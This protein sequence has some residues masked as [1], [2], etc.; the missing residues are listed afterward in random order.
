[1]GIFSNIISNVSGFINTIKDKPVTTGIAISQITNP[2][3]GVPTIANILTQKPSTTV[4]TMQTVNSATGIVAGGATTYATK[5]L[6]LGAG[7]SSIFGGVSALSM[8]ETS[9]KTSTLTKAAENLGVSKI[10]DVTKFVSD[11]P[12]GTATAAAALPLAIYAGI[13]TAG[14]L[15]TTENTLT[16][17]KN[18]EL[19]SSPN[20]KQNNIPTDNPDIKALNDSIDK[21]H[22][23]ND[24]L[25]QQINNLNATPLRG[26]KE[27]QQISMLQ[28]QLDDTNKRLAALSSTQ[29]TI[30]AAN[31]TTSSPSSPKATS[32]KKK[33]KK[34]SIKRRNTSKKHGK[35][36]STK[37]TKRSK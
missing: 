9:P 26:K 36:K 4:S 34:K 33:R 7:A 27:D 21:L 15:N 14:F 28:T 12:A 32:K 10:G 3:I 16:T 13:K 8:L 20:N 5:S 30:I 17:H 29:S 22:Q 19:S 1:M 37:R 24:A 18:N 2:I 11:H 35:R 23:Q 31:P 6:A 25:T